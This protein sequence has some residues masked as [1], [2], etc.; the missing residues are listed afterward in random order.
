MIFADRGLRECAGTDSS[1]GAFS[2][3]GYTGRGGW[4]SVAPPFTPMRSGRAASHA[5]ICC[6]Q[7]GAKAQP[8]G[9]ASSAGTAPGTGT[10][11]SR[12]RRGAARSSPWVYGCARMAQHL[13][14][15][16][17]FDDAAGVHHGNAIGH[18]RDH[19]EIVRD[20]EQRELKIAAQRGEQFEDLFL[21]GDVE[22]GGR[23]VGDE[24][25]RARRERHRDH[26]ALPQAARKLVR[27]LARAAGGLGNRGAFEKIDRRGGGFPGARAQARGRGSLLRSARPRG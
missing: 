17:F 21:H 23:L 13:G 22:R 20:E 19:A 16:S 27:I 12:V 11:F 26:H 1:R 24:H 25:V 18:L 6:G 10:S 15:W 14:D 8:G 3:Q 4:S 5:G 2:G 9:R 7:R